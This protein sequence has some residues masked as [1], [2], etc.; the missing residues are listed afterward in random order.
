MCVCVETERKYVCVP[1]L[2]WKEKGCVYVDEKC[3]CVCVEAER[4]SMCVCLRENVC[5]CV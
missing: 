5:V 1:V 4:K 3:V 2:R